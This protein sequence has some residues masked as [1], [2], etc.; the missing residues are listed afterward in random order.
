MIG[1]GR[2]V[3]ALLLGGLVSGG[4]MA[5]ADRA[6]DPCPTRLEQSGYRLVRETA[7]GARAEAMEAARVKA[8]AGV[9]APFCAAERARTALCQRAEAAAQQVG[10]GAYDPGRRLA[11]A[12]MALDLEAVEAPGQAL[13]PVAEAL[14]S[15]ARRMSGQIGAGTVAVG[16]VRQAGSGCAA[17]A[18][19]D[20]LRNLFIGGLSGPVLVDGAG[21]AAWTVK[22]EVSEAGGMVALS[23]RLEGAGAS[24]ADAIRFPANGLPALPR[25]TCGGLPVAEDRWVEAGLQTAEV[26]LSVGETSLCPGQV[27]TPEVALGGPARLRVYSVGAEGII[28]VWPMFSTQDRVFGPW[29]APKL[30]RMKAGGSGEMNL[31]MVAF[32]PEVTP[33]PAGICRRARLPGQA[34]DSTA[35]WV[36]LEGG[37]CGAGS[38]GQAGAVMQEAMELPECGELV[39][40]VR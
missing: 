23:V 26:R 11:C 22:M 25:A 28:Q 14:W 38:V 13:A 35:L 32:P 15:L 39:E 29:E 37:R 2:S 17:G 1:R 8:L 7:G 27:F 6:E 36:E 9:L 4:E 20:H 19:G 16:A 21:E 33:P 31:V 12:S 34:A 5:Q 40:A 24:L 18:L 30:G 3:F 10:S